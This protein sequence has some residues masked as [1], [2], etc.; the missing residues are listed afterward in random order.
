M[1]YDFSFQIKVSDE[2]GL[3]RRKHVTKHKVILHW[4]RI[5]TGGYLSLMFLRLMFIY[6]R[7][8]ISAG[9]RLLLLV[10]MTLH[11]LH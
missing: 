9:S 11:V 1:I 7:E 6:T 2:Y 4:H 10:F 3:L 5:K 8:I